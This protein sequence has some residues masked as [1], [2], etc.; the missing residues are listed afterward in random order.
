MAQTDP[1]FT[2][3]TM[4]RNL[5]LEVV[6]VTEMAAIAA[7]RLMGR[8]SKNESDQAAVDAM[9]RA[10]D[11]LNIDGTVVIGEG[12]R[13]EGRCSTSEKRSEGASMEARK[14]T[15]RSTPWREPI[16]AP[17]EDLARSP[18]SRLRAG[19]IC[20]TPRIRT[21]RSSPWAPRPEEPSI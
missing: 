16:C 15:S 13:D 21:W 6:R 19:E 20:S 9:R 1:G 10:F 3:G 5:A 12:E 7:A 2:D 4:D 17:M 11:A 18:W 8:G 14:S